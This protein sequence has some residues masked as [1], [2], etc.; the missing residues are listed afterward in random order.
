MSE[1]RRVIHAGRREL[2]SYSDTLAS[3][4]IASPHHPL[5]NTVH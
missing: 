1:V 4:L 5:I 2:I 3:R